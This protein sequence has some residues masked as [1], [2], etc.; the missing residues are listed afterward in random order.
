MK[1]KKSFFIHIYIYI[2][3]LSLKL[4]NFFLLSSRMKKKFFFFSLGMKSKLL[5]KFRDQNS[6]LPFFF[7]FKKNI[8]YL[9][10][11]SGNGNFI[12]VRFAPRGFSPPRKGRKVGMRQN[13]SPAPQGGDGFR[14]FKPT[15]SYPAL[16]RVIIV[17]FSYPK[18]LLFKQTYQY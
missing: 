6:I 8:L 3:I 1:K 17:N 2:Y 15:P 10:P 7:F 12:P 9:F 4:L 14:H 13:F 11:S 16:L 18:T 5:I